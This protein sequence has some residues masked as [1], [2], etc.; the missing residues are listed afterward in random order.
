VCVVNLNV[1]RRAD[2]DGLLEEVV[3]VGYLVACYWNRIGA[4]KTCCK[5]RFGYRYLMRARHVVEV[6]VGWQVVGCAAVETGVG[7]C[8]LT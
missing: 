4:E 5:R 8:P 2:G 6:V 3:E 7:W 1:C